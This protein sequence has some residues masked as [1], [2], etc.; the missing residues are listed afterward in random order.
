MILDPH[1]KKVAVDLAKQAGEI[2]RRYFR[3]GIEVTTKDNNTPL[4]IADTAINDLVVQTIHHEFP[5]HGII[6]EEGGTNYVDQ[7]FA[8]V[9]DPIDGTI[10]FARHIPT[11]AFS[12]AL[13]KGGK[14]VLGV[15]Y[16]PND[17]SLYVAEAGQGTTLNGTPIQVSGPAVIRPMV[18]NLTW[19]NNVYATQNVFPALIRKSIDVMYLHSNVYMGI[20]VARGDLDGLIFPGLQPW[21]CAAIKLIV[22]EAGGKV[23]DLFGNE[24]RYDREIKGMIASNGI[25]HDRLVG[26]VR[27]SGALDGKAGSM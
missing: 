9:C 4:T 25:L 14:P 16:D 22:E 5:S 2:M 7:E 8:W 18:G 26:L 23:T 17:D 12:L 24:Q 6:A 11:S 3:R 15:V 21:D 13:V 10:S 27:E 1:Y 19:V 20:L